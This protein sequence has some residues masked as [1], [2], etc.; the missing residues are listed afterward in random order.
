MLKMRGGRK[1]IKR[2]GEGAVVKEIA[3]FCYWPCVSLPREGEVRIEVHVQL[4]QTLLF[5][6]AGS[7]LLLGRCDSDC[8]APG[9]LEQSADR[10]MASFTETSYSEKQTGKRQ[11]RARRD[12]ADFNSGVSTLFHGGPIIADSLLTG[13]SPD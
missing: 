1:K 6:A 3:R 11:P 12:T 2:E 4:E 8:R 9:S 5:T 10:C 13:S 7:A